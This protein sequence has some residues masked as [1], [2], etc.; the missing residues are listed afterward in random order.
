LTLRRVPI[1]AGSR[2]W[3]QTRSAAVA[4]AKPEP[5]ERRGAVAGD[6]DHDAA[7]GR[8]F[9]QVRGEHAHR[10]VLGS[11]GPRIDRLHRSELGATGGVARLA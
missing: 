9:V 4:T 2:K 1:S 8:M 5:G 10:V 7:G 3:T 11:G 6:V